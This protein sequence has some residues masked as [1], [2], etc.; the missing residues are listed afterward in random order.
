MEGISKDMAPLSGDVEGTAKRIDGVVGEF[1]DMGSDGLAFAGG[2][3]QWGQE[4]PELSL[5]TA[6]TPRGAGPRPTATAPPA[7]GR[8]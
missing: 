5:F 1:R 2:A 8:R 3:P 6:R 7:S 4:I